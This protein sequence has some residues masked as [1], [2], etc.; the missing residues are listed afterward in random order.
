MHPH[1]SV[2]IVPRRNFASIAISSIA[3]IGLFSVAGCQT[4]R[5]GPSEVDADAPTEFTVTESGLKYRILRRGTG[6]QP[7]PAN[8]VTV[9]YRGWL[10]NGRTFDQSYNSSAPATFQLSGVVPGWTEGLQLLREG[11]MMELEIP[12]QLA[13]GAQSQPGIPANS[14]LHFRVELHEVN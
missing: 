5:A 6:P 3:L 12:P 9:D 7:T 10:D 2:R 1:L 4:R 11:G 8:R 14:T 13:Y